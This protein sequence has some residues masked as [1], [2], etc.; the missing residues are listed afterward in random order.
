MLI[1]FSIQVEHFKEKRKKKM[2]FMSCFASHR[3]FGNLPD[4]LFLFI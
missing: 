2:R 3:A 4:L 1:E